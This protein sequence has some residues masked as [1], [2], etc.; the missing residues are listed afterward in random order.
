MAENAKGASVGQP[1]A[2]IDTDPL[3]HKLSGDDAASFSIDD[4]GQITTK[5]KLDYETKSSY[6]VTLTATDPSG[7]SASIVVNIT[8]TDVDD[9]AVI[10]GVVEIDYAENGTEPVGRF[11]A[12]DADGD[13]IEWSLSGDDAGKFA[14]S[15][16]GVLSFK[17]SPNYESPAD[18]DKDNVYM[19]T[20]EAAEGSKAVA[21][22][23]TNVDE[24]GSVKLDEQQPQAGGGQSVT[25]SVSDTDGGV[26]NAVW[27]W[28]RSM[29]MTSWTDISAGTASTYTPQEE[30]EGYYLRATATYSDGVGDERDT[31]SADTAFPVEIRPTANFRPSFVV[32]DE[33]ADQTGIQVTRSVK[34]TAKAGSGVGV[35][36]VAT[37]ADNDPLLYTLDKVTVVTSDAGVSP[38]TTTDVVVID[39]GE[40]TALGGD[41]DTEVDVTNLFAIN[42]KTGQISVKSDA[43]TDLLDIETYPNTYIVPVPTGDADTNKPLAYDVQVTATD[44]SGA[45]A[46]VTVTIKVDPVN[47][48]PKITG[49]APSTTAIT[50]DPDRF[51]VKT[52]ESVQLVLSTGAAGTDALTA[53]PTLVATDPEGAV[54]G[55]TAL[56]DDRIKWSL[57][58]PDAG[59][60]EIVR[61]P[62]TVFDDLTDDPRVLEDDGVVEGLLRWKK[63]PY[64]NFEDMDSADGDNVY[65]VDSDSH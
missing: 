52:P 25:A 62:D 51:N 40:N 42:P 65:E 33:K 45:T 57:S 17:K 7:A 22:T 37:D 12:T 38:V 43:D 55:Q 24:A 5:V 4:S 50:I 56:K 13:A 28:S 1:V 18:A 9:P 26:T 61:D 15:D 35:P 36:V 6:T 44:P 30:D 2:G 10:A 54:E 29:D 34:E 47:E 59:R 63:E 64:P 19:V 14:I 32:Q 60:F 3:K 39:L 31:A 21:V 48:A 20:L 23:V 41:D 27:Q 8:V 11:S 58:G 53:L 16:D 49:L 46:T